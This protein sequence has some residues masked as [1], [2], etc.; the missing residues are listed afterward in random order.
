MNRSNVTDFI[1]H[2]H[3]RLLAALDSGRQLRER[4]LAAHT[5][6]EHL[7]LFTFGSNRKAAWQ[8]VN[9][10]IGLSSTD[11]QQRLEEQMHNR[12]FSKRMP[13]CMNASCPD[14]DLQ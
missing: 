7:R 10:L 13:A 9:N 4:S 14:P 5:M 3:A 12:L 1:Q 2:M 6:S 11:W 8:E